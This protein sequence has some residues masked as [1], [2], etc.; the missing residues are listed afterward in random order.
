MNILTR[1]FRRRTTCTE[2]GRLGGMVKHERQR[3]IYK[4]KARQMRADMGLPPLEILQ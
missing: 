4:A 1:I 3:A 2:A